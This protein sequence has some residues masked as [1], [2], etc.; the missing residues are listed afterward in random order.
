MHS[1][2]FQMSQD[3]HRCPYHIQ[4]T[5]LLPPSWCPS[6]RAEQH[7]CVNACTLH[8]PGLW[9]WNLPTAL[10][11]VPINNTPWRV[12]HS[13]TVLGMLRLLQAN[14]WV[15]VAFHVI[16]LAVL[17]VTSGSVQSIFTPGSALGWVLSVA[18]SSRSHSKSLF[19]PFSM[20]TLH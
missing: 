17:H 10:R 4:E 18:P 19:S 14:I 1:F 9:N 7:A 6:W 13:E 8:P 11:V 2:T 20:S 12:V 3:N 16:S 5:N 15:I